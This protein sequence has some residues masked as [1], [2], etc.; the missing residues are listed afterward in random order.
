MIRFV[1]AIGLVFGALPAFA[2]GP[3]LVE[4]E[5]LSRTHTDLP[6]VAERVPADPYVVDLEAKGRAVGKHGGDLSTMIGRSKDVRLINVWGYARLVGYDEHYELQPDILKAVDEE[7]G[8]IF[9]FHLR[10]GHKWSDGEPF[11]SEDFRYW[12]EDVLTNTDLTPTPSPFMLAGGKLPQFE[13]LDETTVRFTWEDPNPVFLPTLAQA[14]PPFMYRP[15]HYL[16]QFNPK[17]G[18]A[19][20]IAK[21][22]DEARVRSWA[23]LHNIKDEM[24]DATNPDLPSL[25]PWVL[26]PETSDRRA[27]MVRN[28]YFHRV[29]STGQ[30][31]PYIDRVIMTVVDGGLIAT[32]V[33][34]GDADLQARG[35]AFSDL[36]VLKRGEEARGYKAALWPQANA[37]AMAIYPNLTVTDPELRKL[38]RDQRFRQA[39]SLA[40]DRELLNRVLYFG[41]G[42]PSANIVLADSPLYSEAVAAAPPFDTEKANAL[43]D[44]IGLTERNGDGL[45]LLPD[46]RPLELIVETAGEESIQIDA[47]EL[48]TDGWREIGIALFPRPSQRD[49]L[50]N[51]AFSGD[52]AM[53]VWFGY[54]NG[55]PSEAMPPD[56]RVPV[57]EQFLTGPAWGAYVTSGG[58][59]GEK[60]DYPPVVELLAL[61]DAWM[62]SETAAEREAAWMDILR[63]HGEEVLTLGTV[64]GV[65]QPVV[66]SNDLKNVPMKGTYGWDPG[67][68]FGI[69]RPD[70]F[71]F[72]TGQ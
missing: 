61:Y 68:Q 3:T 62:T 51:R 30:Q 66:I 48:I 24:Y 9:T 25:Q 34:A 59:S 39:L 5:T 54:D 36:P 13:V 2:A 31:L 47:L 55:I 22:A 71:F 32:K 44:E 26:S 12:F 33:Q 40:I 35:L 70:E 11:T 46:G 43:L 29:T 18:D 15:A 8:R 67:A 50:R 57:S 16:K 7:D 10:Q 65:V 21:M 23:P 28:P 53:G 60:P 45:R 63:I 41:L 42:Q 38:F 56:E 14:R 20:A 37:S 4:T 69:Y 49:V 27:V 17:Y 6:P 72:A 19:D 52:L 64:Q 1:V 58:Q